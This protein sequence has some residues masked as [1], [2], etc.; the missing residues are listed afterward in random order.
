MPYTST[1][2]DLNQYEI[3]NLNSEISTSLVNS[4]VEIM[5]TTPS[6]VII[7]FLPE[8][9]CDL[10]NVEGT[11]NFKRNITPSKPIAYF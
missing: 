11:L 6:V 10:S 2:I 1:N 8:K 5:D 3:S 4:E 7:E 9:A